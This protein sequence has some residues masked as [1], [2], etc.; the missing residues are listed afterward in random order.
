MKL[1]IYRTMKLNGVKVIYEKVTHNIYDMDGNFLCV[2]FLD[3]NK[4]TKATFVGE[5]SGKPKLVDDVK[6]DI[7]KEGE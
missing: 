7:I 1:D 3:G 6:L 5:T 2:G 4:L